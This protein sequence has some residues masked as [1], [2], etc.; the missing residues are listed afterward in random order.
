MSMNRVANLVTGV[1]AMMA[2][3]LGGRAIWNQVRP[4][5]RV[6]PRISEERAW[7]EIAAAGTLVKGDSGAVT[8]VEFGDFECVFCQRFAVHLDSLRAAGVPFQFVYRHALN[9]QSPSSVVSARASECARQ[10]GR[11]PSA[12]ELL[13][14]SGEARSGTFEEIRRSIGALDSAR[15]HECVVEEG[16]APMLATDSAAAARLGVRGTPTILVERIRYDGLP[17]FDSLLA[18]VRRARGET[19]AVR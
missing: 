14:K 7:P 8:I 4:D 18:F 19:V 3:A 5:S 1:L 10:Q 2:M 13:M 15:F 16:W 12:Y 9:R 11:F 17:S 6:L